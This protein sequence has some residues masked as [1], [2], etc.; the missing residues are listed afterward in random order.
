MNSHDDWEILLVEDSAADAELIVLGLRESHPKCVVRHTVTGEDA[1]QLLRFG[2][3]GRKI[4]LV[5]LDLNLPGMSGS[6]V[7]EEIRADPNLQLLPVVVLTTSDNEDEVR[8]LYDRRANAF[9]VKPLGLSGYRE[10]LTNLHSFWAGSARIPSRTRRCHV[11]VR[12]RDRE[13]I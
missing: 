5:L 9:I 2:E 13:V 12:D 3:I 6:E 8:S 4:G 11:G 7:L 10:V 1:L